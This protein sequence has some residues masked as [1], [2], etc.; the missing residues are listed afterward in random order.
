MRLVL[1]PLKFNHSFLLLCPPKPIYCEHWIRCGTLHLALLNLMRFPWHTSWVCPG[2][3]EFHLIPQMCQLRHSALSANSLWV[4]LIL[5]SL[6]KIL[7]GAGPSTDPSGTPLSTGETFRWPSY[8]A[9]LVQ[10]LETKDKK[11]WNL[12]FLFGDFLGRDTLGAESTLFWISI[13]S[14]FIYDL[15]DS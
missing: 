5:L 4:H 9:S 12:S 6:M 10:H 14:L 1:N 11:W 7:N 13:F 15:A 3:S 8:L 2:P